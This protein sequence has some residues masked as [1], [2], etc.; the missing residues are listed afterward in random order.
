[1]NPE[2]LEI[3]NGLPGEA[4]IREGLN[5]LRQSQHTIPSCLVRIARPRLVRAGMIER[6][7]PDD[8]NAELQLY[9]L[10]DAEGALA[11]SRYN[12]LI[13][14]LI[15]FEHALDHRMSRRAEAEER[16]R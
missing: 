9:D 16:A 3:L 10:L 6:N 2:S 14:E 11:H 5:D 12:A 15:S 13:R 1:M 4:R 8:L 7:D